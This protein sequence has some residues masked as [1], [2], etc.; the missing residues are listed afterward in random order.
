MMDLMIKTILKPILSLAMLLMATGISNG[1]NIV[2]YMPTWSGSV[3]N[4]RY[5]KFTHI[6]FS[7]ILPTNT[8]DLSSLSSGNSNKLNTL[9]SLGHA[10]NVKILIA[11]GGYNNGNDSGFK[12]LADDSTG[13]ANFSVNVMNFVNT[14]NLDGVDIDWEF[15]DPGVEADN[16][17][18][19]MK[20][21]SDT[22]HHYGKILTA[23]VV[24]RGTLGEGIKTEVFDYVDFFN[25]M[26]YDAGA[27]HSS[28]GEASSSLIYWKDRGVPANK[29]ILGVPFYGK[30]ATQIYSYSAIVQSDPQA[31]YKD[32][33]GTI[34]YNGL[35]T[36]KNKTQLAKLNGGGIMI[37]EITQDTN[38][39]ATSLLTAIYTKIH[40]P[41][42]TTTPA[43]EAAIVI[44]PNPASNQT[45]VRLE[46]H[47]QG[48][49]MS[50]TISDATG[51]E[52]IQLNDLTP[53]IEEKIN[54]DILPE[55]FYFLKINVEDKSILKKLI[56]RK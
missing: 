52:L 17:A 10:N 6:N 14:Y 47:F 37:W 15:P 51:K 50:I 13:R 7:F 35:Q 29:C 24:S 21:L 28:Y 44:Y 23:A 42:G 55:G 16:Y 5:D 56:I 11:I 46:K 33:S 19:M 25:L 48:K 54:V 39:D 40:G 4:I 18:L 26:A 20:Q 45:M 22:L 8:G 12:N 38:N 49:T 43:D 31:P 36:I 30:D 9:C 34:N 32:N 3:S 53:A 2:G 41:N 1:F 27:P